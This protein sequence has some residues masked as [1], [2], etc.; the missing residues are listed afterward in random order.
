MIGREVVE[1]IEKE[2]LRLPERLVKIEVHFLGGDGVVDSG[3]ERPGS[4]ESDEVEIDGRF[5]ELS[6][7]RPK[8]PCHGRRAFREAG[9]PGL[10]QADVTAAARRRRSAV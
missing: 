5:H 2:D 9:V 3:L 10:R 8:P 4:V 6:I 1:R 7:A